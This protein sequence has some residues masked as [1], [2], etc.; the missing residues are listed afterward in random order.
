MG[1]TFFIFMR[2]PHGAIGYRYLWAESPDSQISHTSWIYAILDY[3]IEQSPRFDCL[4][5]HTHRPKFNMAVSTACNH[6]INFTECR[7]NTMT[8]RALPR[9]INDV[10]ARRSFV[11]LCDNM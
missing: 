6:L 7:Q 5:F 1:A 4:L 11:V 2:L 10:N 8:S 9:T 3:L